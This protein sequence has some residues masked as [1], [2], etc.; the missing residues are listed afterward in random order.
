MDDNREL[1]D[2]GDLIDPEQS[3]DLRDY[4]RVVLKHRRMAV[5]IFSVIFFFAL[6]VNFTATPMYQARATLIIEKDSPNTLNFNEY[7][8]SDPFSVEWY[9]TQYKILESRVL[10]RKVIDRLGL[11]ENAKFF[12]RPKQDTE[13]AGGEEDKTLF[14]N[15]LISF[16]LGGLRIEP[17]RNTRLVG[18]SY[19]SPDP[20]LAAEIA[21]GVIQT[22]I[23]YNFENKVD[24]VKYSVQWLNENMEAERR[25]VEAAEAAL[26]SY[27]Q[28]FDIVTDF[29]GD[30]E[31][32]TAQKLAQLNSQVVEAETARVEAETR[33]NQAVEFAKNPDMLDSIPD[34]LS[35]TII[36]QIKTMEVEL[37][38]KKSEL[39]KKYGANHPQMVALQS[40]LRNLRSK[41]EQEISRI[42][43]SL[44]NN[45]KIALAKENSL[46][47]ALDAQKN[48][49]LDLNQKAV[50]YTNLYRQAES[51]KEMY[52]L[53]LRRFKEKSV[54]ESLKTDNIRMVD[55]AEVPRFPVKPRKARNM[56][57]AI[58]LGLGLAVGM[59]FFL[60]YLN[61]T[62]SSPEDIK[63]HL[64]IPFLGLVPLHGAKEGGLM[65]ATTTPP[66]LETFHTPRSNISEF[67]RALRT[68]ILF[69][70]ADAELRV[71]LVSSTVAQEGKTTTAVNL[72][73]VMAQYGYKVALIDGDFH[74]PQ[75]RKLFGI[76]QEEGLSN[77]LVHN[78]TLSE[79]VFQT[80][81]PNLFVLPSGRLPP[82]P[83]EILGSR[84]MHSLLEQL[85]Q[86]FKMIIID[87]P[88]LAGV[89]DTLVTANVAD[90]AV[91]VVR[92][93]ATPRGIV[94]SALENLEGIGAKVLGAVLNAYDTTTVGYYYSR[95]Y[96]G[97]T[98]ASDSKK[99]AH[100]KSKGLLSKIPFFGRAS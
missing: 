33:Y 65:Q 83:S 79:A 54:S 32:I 98:Y 5:A 38:Q 93:G 88:P 46:K 8:F 74:R 100:K 86:N 97:Y 58:V 3:I 63:R 2:G 57:I 29:T 35:N 49:S 56:L 52:A 45:Y 48:Q 4:M 17:L 10:A 84:A 59:A 92:A 27:K 25:K 22:Y 30:T 71:L 68:N 95:H 19:L 12:P 44:Q 62:L 77:L 67:Y 87:S 81:I 13:H 90:G 6:F 40:E 70:R 16:F 39:S 60:E 28:K 66:A 78:K 24:A 31:T 82:N 94:Q 36:Q 7:I 14:Y 41:K 91:L 89:T 23:D 80:K 96:Y 50:E 42:V 85:K 69:S 34:V 51:A 64:R 37:S 18:V 21:N 20:D 47:Q 72:A 9:Q 99:K 15:N 53:L 75:L 43:N 1:F 11:A 55:K 76:R 26:L 73:I 61:N